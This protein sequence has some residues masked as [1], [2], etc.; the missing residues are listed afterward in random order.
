MINV[1]QLYSLIEGLW[2]YTKQY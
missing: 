2:E 1:C